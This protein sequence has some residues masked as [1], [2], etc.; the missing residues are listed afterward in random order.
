MSQR[1]SEPVLTLNVDNHFGSGRLFLSTKAD[2]AIAEE[3]IPIK[4]PSMDRFES[5]ARLRMEVRASFI[6]VKSCQTGQKMRRFFG[7]ISGNFGDE[8]ER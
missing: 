3:K 2:T 1:R 7:M 6:V 8:F 5:R 4:Q